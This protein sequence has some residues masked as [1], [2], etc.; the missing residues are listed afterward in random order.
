MFYKLLDAKKTV[1]EF[2]KDY[3]EKRKA[4][5]AATWFSEDLEY[6]GSNPNEICNDK[7]S[8]TEIFEND[9]ETFPF[10][11]K[12]Y[13]KELNENKL[14]ESISLVNVIIVLYRNNEKFK[15]NVRYSMICKNNGEGYKI[16]SAHCSFPDES[17]KYM[18]KRL[19]KISKELSLNEIVLKISLDQSNI[20]FWEYDIDNDIYIP[21]YKI[22]DRFNFPDHIKNGVQSL[23]N[24]NIIHPDSIEDFREMHEK[25]KSGKKSVTKILKLVYDDD[26]QWKKIKY[27]LVEDEKSRNSRAVGISKD[28]TREKSLENLMESI[29]Y[30]EFDFIIKINSRN[31]NYKFYTDKDYI[32]NLEGQDG[33]DIKKIFQYFLEKYVK[34]E[35]R[36]RFQECFNFDYIVKNI[37]KQRDI[38][39]YYEGYDRD[40]NIRIKKIKAFYLNKYSEVFYVVRT[41]VTDVYEKQKNNIEALELA[42][43]SAESSKLAKAEFLS[44][45]SHEIRT[46]IN[47]IVGMSEI[48]STEIEYEKKEEIK[49][50][51]MKIKSSSDY[52]LSLINNILKMSK[53]E[54]GKLILDKKMIDMD[55][56]FE[57]INLMCL[58]QAKKKNIDYK[59]FKSETLKK[60]YIGD[61]IRLKQVLINIISNAIKFTDNLGRVFFKCEEIFEEKGLAKLLFTVEDTGCG[62]SKE[63]IK[64]I[65]KPFSQE[66]L[67]TSSKYG[68]SGLGLAISK[69][70][71]DLMNGDIEIESEKNKGTKFKIKVILETNHLNRDTVNCD[72]RKLKENKKENKNI[73]FKGEKILVVEDHE[74]NIEVIKK[75]LLYVGLK[76]EV[77]KNGLEAVQKFQLFSK[78]YSAILMDIRMP[79]MDGIEATKKIRN[80]GREE[81]RKIPII[82]VTAGAFESEKEEVLKAGMNDSLTKP[83]N[84]DELYSILYKYIPKIKSR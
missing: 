62:V 73:S 21:G 26:V 82:A 50:Y 23:I 13:I 10:N 67:G 47:V 33:K 44:R 75:L 38:I 3:F 78:E 68:G 30:S 42:L 19:D 57:E 36:V 15:I 5:E 60:H 46:P 17:Q 61:E 16:F 72:S 55:S 43:K 53:I 79:V 35:E 58:T 18:E 8:L 37:K 71:V 20:Y 70:I 31:R 56:L 64:H 39:F 54:S 34:E 84:K 27:Q 14:T 9:I 52:L 83:I 51:L 2:L 6:I 76:V 22:K 45:M 7:K 29:L 32:N 12:V 65:F 69:N 81:S 74:L 80:L 11:M 49:S 48:A 63:F 66:G 41:D 59:F 1:E 4:M 77:A 28:I 25:L 24:L 40:G